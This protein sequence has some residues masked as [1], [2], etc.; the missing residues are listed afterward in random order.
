MARF[1]V[2]NRQQ[3]N[4]CNFEI[5]LWAWVMLNTMRKVACEYL[6]KIKTLSTLTSSNFCISTLDPIWKL[7]LT[8]PYDLQLL[9]WWNP[10][11]SNPMLKTTCGVG[12]AHK[13]ATY[14]SWFFNSWRF[15][16]KVAKSSLSIAKTGLHNHLNEQNNLGG[17][18]LRL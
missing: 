2:K 18:H 11:M 10:S 12:S 3:K 8:Y 1:I 15:W 6:K 7:E 9:T 4:M 5:R 17:V 14:L 16:F 13:R